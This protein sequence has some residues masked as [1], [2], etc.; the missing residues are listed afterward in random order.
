M[1]PASLDLTIIKIQITKPKSGEDDLKAIILEACRIEKELQAKSGMVVIQDP[2]GSLH[3]EQA[4]FTLTT[5]DSDAITT[6]PPDTP[7]KPT[8]GLQ[9]NKTRSII[10]LTA[11]SD[12]DTS[13]PTQRVHAAAEVAVK[14]EIVDDDVVAGA[15]NRNKGPVKPAKDGATNGGFKVATKSYRHGDGNALAKIPKAEVI[16]ANIADGLSPQAQEKREVSR[17]NLL[18]ETV[19]QERND[20]AIDE[21]VQDLKR[22]IQDLKKE[23]DELRREN[24]YYRDRATEAAT[25]LSIL[26]TADHSFTSVHNRPT[27]YTPASPAFTANPGFYTVPSTDHQSTEPENVAGPGPQTMYYRQQ[28]AEFEVDDSEIAEE[29]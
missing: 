13:P 25:A 20:R 11:V 24:M 17:M 14:Q 3:W 16:L 2:P 10:D 21:R 29:E 12:N 6:P 19:N 9:K 27:P 28:A 23:V 8:G 18:R 26:S 15:T 7:A 1:C 5:E 4:Y 22:E